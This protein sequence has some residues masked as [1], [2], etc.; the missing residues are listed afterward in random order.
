ML[1]NAAPAKC[2]EDTAAIS[3]DKDAQSISNEYKTSNSSAFPK[4]S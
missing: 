1:N 2:N 3:D 4:L